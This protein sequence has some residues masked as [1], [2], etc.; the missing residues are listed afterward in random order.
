MK[1]AIKICCLHVVVNDCH[2][3]VSVIINVTVKLAY[4]ISSQVTPPFTTHEK[5]TEMTVNKSPG[6]LSPGPLGQILHYR[7]YELHAVI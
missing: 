5:M 2:Q 3:Y 4:R 7:L 6:H 1:T